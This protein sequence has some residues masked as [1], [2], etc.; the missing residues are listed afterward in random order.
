MKDLSKL[1]DPF[2]ESDVEWRIGQSGA[3]NGKP[4]A[5]V[6]AYITNR[7]IQERLDEV[8]GPLGWKN[9]YAPGP[10]GGVVCGISVWDDENKQWV[11]K[12]DGASN[13]EVKDGGKLDE[14]TNIKGGLSASMKRAGAQWGIGRYL[15]NLPRG[16]AVFGNGG[17]YKNKIK[18]SDTGK[19]DWYDWSPP[20]L[21]AWALPGGSGKPNAAP[22]RPAPEKPAA[23]AAIAV[24]A[25]AS[26]A[27]PAT[28]ATTTVPDTIDS[29][30]AGA[31]KMVEDKEVFTSAE[32]AEFYGALGLASKTLDGMRALYKKWADVYAARKKQAA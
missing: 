20:A 18:D 31:K 15:Y 3:K 29:L 21:P 9:E 26:E 19:E 1:S 25:A 17:E 28:P 23:P 32:R 11:T 4:W 7:A 14:D 24:E 27:S 5:Y 6:L 30:R 2:P 13:T 8:C 22:T 12:W 16:K 10:G